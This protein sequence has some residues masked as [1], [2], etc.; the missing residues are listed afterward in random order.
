MVDLPPQMRPSRNITALL[1]ALDSEDPT[2]R[3]ALHQ[4]L[5]VTNLVHRRKIESEFAQHRLHHDEYQNRKYRFLTDGA[6]VEWT[7]NK[8]KE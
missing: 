8:P 2:V 7:W 4:L 3:T 6:R 5:V 1:V